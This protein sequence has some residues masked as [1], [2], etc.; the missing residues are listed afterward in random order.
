MI[1][2]SALFVNAKLER[3]TSIYFMLLSLLLRNAQNISMWSDP[4]VTCKCVVKHILRCPH[5]EVVK[6]G[7]NNEYHD[8]A[9][10]F[11]TA[12]T[13]DCKFHTRAHLGISG[14]YVRIP[15]LLYGDSASIEDI[16]RWV[17]LMNREG[18]GRTRFWHVWG[19]MAVFSCRY[20]QKL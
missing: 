19:I 6:L 8:N 15:G 9:V 13:P 5:I 17:C 1:P 20:W 2:N 14:V 12:P 11:R 10:S 4:L 3:N 16:V 18:C 7:N